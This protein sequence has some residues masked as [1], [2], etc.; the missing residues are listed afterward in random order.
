M[1][2]AGGAP[3]VIPRDWVRLGVLVDPV[4]EQVQDIWNSWHVTYHGTSKEA[5]LSIFEQRQFSIPGDQLLGV[6]FLAMRPGHIPEKQYI[7][8]SSTIAYSSLPV[9]CPSYGFTSKQNQ[10]YYV[11][12]V[13]ECRQNPQL[14]QIQSETVGKGRRRICPFIPNSKIEYFTEVRASLVVYGLLLNFEERY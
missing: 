8:T 4:V 12:I 13:L 1:L 3:Y 6:N 7:Y 9:Y 14:M 11:K 5:A 10:R 2:Q